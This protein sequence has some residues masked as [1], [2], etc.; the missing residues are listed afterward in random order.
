MKGGNGQWSAKCPAHGDNHQS[1]SV[2]VGKDGRVLMKCHAGCDVGEI[3]QAI[4]LT[5]KDLFVEQKPPTRREKPS[6]VATYTYPS[7]AQKLRRS[8]KT[9]LWRHRNKAGEWEWNRKGIPYELYIAGKLGGMIHVVEG[10]K[11]ADNFSSRLGGC[12]VCGQD[13]AGPGKWRQEYTEQLR[14]LPVVIIQ[15]NDDVGRAY[16]Q[17]TA[18]ALHGVAQ[19]VRLVDLSRCWPEIPE[20]GDISDMIEAKGAEKAARLLVELER[21]TP[22]WVPG[23]AEPDPLLSLFKA[24][25]DFPEED[26]KWLIPGWI[27]EGQISIIAADGGIGKTTIWCNVIAALS[28]GTACILDPP[29]TVRAPMK[30]MFLTTEDSVRKS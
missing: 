6:V 7:G 16:A 30:V 19:S 29:G 8:D 24:L 9:F 13:G 25:D 11:D 28:N 15:D 4:G 27:P 26:A 2:S 5:V 18:A 12:A 21:D 20:H 14:G 10:E 17:E 22:E 1:L 3:A 23:S